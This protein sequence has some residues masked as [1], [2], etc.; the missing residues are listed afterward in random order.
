MS[1]LHGDLLMM[2]KIAVLGLGNIAKRHRKNLKTKFPDSNLLAMSSS[3]RV[4]DEK[5]SYADEVVNNIEELVDA[6][7]LFV[8]V[9]S[10]ATFHLPH[11][12]A[13]L[14][15]NIPVLVEKPVTASLSDAK[16]LSDIAEKY[17][18]PISVGYC[19]RYLSSSIKIKKILEDG[20]IG[21]IYNA[22]AC[23]GQYLPTWRPVKD[24]RQ[25]VSAK[26]SLGGGVLLELSH[27]LDLF[28]WLLGDL[29]F[30][31]AQ[32]RKS[33]ELNLD[34]ESIADIVLS[35]SSGTIC[36]IHL[37]FL[38]KQTHRQ[39]N[40]IGTKGRLDWDLIENTITLHDET[41]SSTIYSEPKW[42]K[43]QMYLSMLDD[44]FLLINNNENSCID[45]HQATK[46]IA[47]IDEI[48]QKAKWGE[49]Q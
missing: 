18:T 36:N 22:S 28:Y 30:K 13:L 35:S 24:Y 2:Q 23:V 6:N 3:G 48:K 32:L 16:N 11:S 17:K 39:C 46:T 45:L 9:A 19:L 20:I 10:P 49:A 29:E 1:I 12:S 43:N 34:V 44:F 42:D 47:L 4:P 37:D 14:K 25:S 7:P 8:I 38:Q 15:A 33:S 41:G 31:Y 26:A 27:E 21:T 40:F 5:V